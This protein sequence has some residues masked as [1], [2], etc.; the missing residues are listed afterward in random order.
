VAIVCSEAFVDGLPE[1]IRDWDLIEVSKELCNDHLGTNH[2]I[3]NDH[4]IIVPAEQ[5]HDGVSAELRKRAF[6]VI[7]LP[8]EAVYRMG[9]SFRCAH[10]PLVRI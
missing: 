4:T 10:Q 5:A 7:R 6:E 9:G 2:L 8:Y 1:P 3:L